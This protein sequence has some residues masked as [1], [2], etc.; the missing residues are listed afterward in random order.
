MTN[1][2][3]KQAYEL[4]RNQQYTP[5]VV[6]NLVLLV[7]VVVSGAI[8]F[9]SLVG[10]IQFDSPNTL[11]QWVEVNSQ[12][13]NACFTITALL[14]QPIRFWL[15]VWTIR[16]RN[17]RNSGDTIERRRYKALIES[18]VP[19][20]KL[21]DEREIESGET[22]V[23][24]S[25]S[26]IQDHPDEV[27]SPAG[28]RLNTKAPQFK[29]WKWYLIVAMLNGQCIF[30]YPI[31]AIQWMYLGRASLRPPWVIPIFLPLS[32]LCGAIGGIWPFLIARDRKKTSLL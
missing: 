10:M 22:S 18:E 19:D 17:A 32:F 15:A 29:T 7:I 30:Q 8:L 11:A 31:T 3:L 27:D 23:R 16:W 4:I 14:T 9:M 28:L 26:Q 24:V 1:K 12:I 2:I 13:L 6:F 20:I 21:E 25:A 5:I